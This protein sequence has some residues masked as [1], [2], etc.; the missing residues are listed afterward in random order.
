MQLDFKGKFYTPVFFVYIGF[1]YK[2]YGFVKT[3]TQESLL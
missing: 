3:S 1:P 2:V